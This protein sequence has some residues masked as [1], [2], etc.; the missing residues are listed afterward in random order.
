MIGTSAPCTESCP[1][2]LDPGVLTG[3]LGCS[4]FRP[5]FEVQCACVHLTEPQHPGQRGASLST[6]FRIVLCQAFLAA[7]A[8]CPDA[9]SREGKCEQHHGKQSSDG[10]YRTMLSTVCMCKRWP[11]LGKSACTTQGLSLRF[12]SNQI[13]GIA[14]F[15][16]LDGGPFATTS[17]QACVT[18]TVD[19]SLRSIVCYVALP[20]TVC[21]PSV[22]CSPSSAVTLRPPMSRVPGKH[23]SN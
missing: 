17:G 2:H 8:K 15:N 21:V 6:T 12:E 11:E 14:F 16:L 13:S 5:T 10:C 4:V 3:C 23:F 1:L 19:D 22:A 18:V 20:S 9:S 7:R